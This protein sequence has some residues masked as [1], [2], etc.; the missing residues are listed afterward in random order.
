M[1]VCSDPPTL[2]G[3]VLNASL[4]FGGKLGGVTGTEIGTDIGRFF[5]GGG[6]FGY[7]ACHFHAITGGGCTKPPTVA[8][9]SMYNSIFSDAFITAMIN[10]ETSGVTQQF[11]DYTCSG[12]EPG[13]NDNSGCNACTTTLNELLASREAL[14]VEANQ[15]NPNYTIEYP[16]N[17]ATQANMTTASF[18]A[19]ACRACYFENTFQNSTVNVS[20]TAVNTEKFVESVRNNLTNSTKQTVKNVTDITGD[21]ASV[22]KNDS[23]CIIANIAS[24]ISSK[25]S[26]EQIVGLLTSSVDAQTLDISGLSVWTDRLKQGV[27]YQSVT[28]LVEQ[29]SYFDSMYSTE[30]VTAAQN[31]VKENDTF[32][33]LV[34]DLDETIVGMADIYKSTIGKTIM[35]VGLVMVG[36]VIIMVILFATNPKLMNDLLGTHA[37]ED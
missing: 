8:N 5:G 7:E 33:Q 25:I 37:K 6:L 12:E 32:N 34:N 23:D 15:I 2:V 9:I 14:E 3:S 4:T 22:F 29:G 21:L 28:S 1:A 36:A 17:A 35:I 11:I 26:D 24:T 10:V 13:Y 18:C 30:D 19:S 20:I 31:I 16:G 27:T